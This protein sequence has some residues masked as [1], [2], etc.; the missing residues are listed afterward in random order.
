M[1]ETIRRKK[2]MIVDDSEIVLA[3]SRRVLE[4]AGFEVITHPRPA[5]CIALIL[6][7]APDLLLVDVNMPGLNGDTVVKMLGSTQ[8]NG[9]MIVLLHSSLQDDILAQK[10]K[11]SHAHGYIRK[12]DNPQ[13]LVREVS[14]WIRPNAGSGAHNM[15]AL[16][17]SRNSSGTMLAGSPVSDLPERSFS[18]DVSAGE[19]QK[20][21]LLVDHDMLALSEYRQLTRSFSGRTEFAL[22]GTEALRRLQSNS[23]PDIVVLGRLLGSPDVNDILRA[24]AQLGTRWK[25]RCIVLHEEAVHDWPPSLEL[26]R[27]T[28]PLTET[29]LCK[30]IQGCLKRAS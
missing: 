25:S 9:T 18:K 5:G 7:E 2:V 15:D 19:G 12:S 24:I 29:S 28:C 6:Q 4:A 21:F 11:S 26:T 27:V 10:A 17:A 3:V 8:A 14:R 22:S 1:I 20:K 30:A 23:P 16:T 13:V